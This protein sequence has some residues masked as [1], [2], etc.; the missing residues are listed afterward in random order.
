MRRTSGGAFVR[1]GSVSLQ[2]AAA[3]ACGGAAPYNASALGYDCALFARKFPRDTASAAQH[4]LAACGS[5]LGIANDGVCN[6]QTEEIPEQ[7]VS[8]AH[9]ARHILLEQEGGWLSHGLAAPERLSGL[10]DRQSWGLPR[11]E[12]YV[13]EWLE[14]R[15]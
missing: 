4:L 8:S 15:L 6:N 5:G 12:V 2:D 10:Q 13:P 11:Q 14:D 7:R 3:G 9:A 1:A